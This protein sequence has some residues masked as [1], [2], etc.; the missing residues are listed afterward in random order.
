MRRGAIFDHD[1]LMF[2]TETIWQ[3]SWR[4]V[5]EEMGVKVPPLF[6][7][8]ICGSNGEGMIRIVEQ[9]FPGLNA[10][11]YVAR[12]V[13]RTDRKE[14][15][16]LPEKKGLREL[17]R[18]FRENGVRMIVASGSM[19]EQ[20]QYNISHAGLDM[21]FTDIV[22]GEDVT[23]GKPAPDIFLKAADKLGLAPEECYVFEDSFNGVRAGHAA[24]C[25]TV[26][27]PDLVEPDEEI[28]GIYDACAESLLEVR[29]R[30]RAGEM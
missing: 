17:L 16:S 30:I 27:V 8:K 23:Y 26:M 28:S 20:V 11:E 12:V 18:F 4:V 22:A 9:F 13:E 14:R 1:G 7:K 21:Y 10:R 3:E 6:A 2:D 29:D 5:A 24:G 15:E 19:R 25:Y